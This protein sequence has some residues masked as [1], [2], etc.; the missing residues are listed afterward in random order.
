MASHPVIC[1]PA[2]FVVV[3][4]GSGADEPESEE[5]LLA[6]PA[7]GAVI[8]GHRSRCRSR[9]TDGFSESSD[10]VPEFSN[11]IVILTHPV[12]FQT[13]RNR[14]IAYTSFAVL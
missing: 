14:V 8:R 4:T 7:D 6:S 9:V 10:V 5:S 2:I 3:S 11:I 12:L 1:S 13:F